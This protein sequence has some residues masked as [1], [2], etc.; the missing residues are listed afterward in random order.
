MRKRRKSVC[1]RPVY[2]DYGYRIADY[3]YMYG[4]FSRERHVT[5]Y[6]VSTRVLEVRYSCYYIL[7]VTASQLHYYYVM[8]YIRVC[9][10]LINLAQFG[11]KQS[12][13][14]MSTIVIAKSIVS[15][16]RSL[17]CRDD[18]DSKWRLFLAVNDNCSVIE[19]RFYVLLLSKHTFH[20][21][22]ALDIHD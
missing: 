19:Q 20:Q 15:A 2:V 14:T 12:C 10:Y 3:G 1:N 9:G 5:L 13:N 11:S 7:L 6:S 18:L 16:A 22:H 8:Y 4:D 17:T 21:F